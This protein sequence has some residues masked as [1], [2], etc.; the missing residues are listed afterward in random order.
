MS[1]THVLNYDFP[2]DI[3]EYVHRVGR[4]GCAGRTGESIT[5][6]TRQDWHHAKGL[7]DILEEANQE[8]SEEVYKM[9]ERCDAWKKKDAE[10]SCVRGFNKNSG[11]SHYRT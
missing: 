3:K 9:A 11:R 2:R 1:L 5:F 10:Q 4:T 7:I 8:V 6:M